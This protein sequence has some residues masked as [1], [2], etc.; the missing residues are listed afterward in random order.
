MIVATK[1]KNLHDSSS[2]FPSDRLEVHTYFRFKTESE[3]RGVTFWFYKSKF[4]FMHDLWNLSSVF[5]TEIHY[6]PLLIICL[7]TEREPRK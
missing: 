6:F 1:K 3:P 5:K 2:V 7:K 4:Q